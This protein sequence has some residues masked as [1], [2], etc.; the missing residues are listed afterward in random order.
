M[1]GDAYRVRLRGSHVWHIPNGNG[2]PLCGEVL[3]HPE[4]QYLPAALAPDDV[5]CERCLSI[6]REREAR[7]RG[8]G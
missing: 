4:R 2:V 7:P 1:A 5:V 8:A 3:Q 6:Y